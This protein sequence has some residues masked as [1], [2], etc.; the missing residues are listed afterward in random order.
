MTR[1]PNIKFTPEIVND[2]A[3]LYASGNFTIPQIADILSERFGGGFTGKT[4]R[5]AIGRHGII[6]GENY[7]TSPKAHPGRGLDTIERI[8]LRR[9]RTPLPPPADVCRIIPAGSL[10]APHG[11]FSMLRRRP[12]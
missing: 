7:Q 3:A 2:L 10:P 9:L 4:I 5:N 6:R 12:V 8:N 11:G 1:R